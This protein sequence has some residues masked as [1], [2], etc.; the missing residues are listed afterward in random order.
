MNLDR[1]LGPRS[2][3]RSTNAAPEFAQGHT[4]CGGDFRKKEILRDCRM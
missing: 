1:V 3:D 4:W 2:R